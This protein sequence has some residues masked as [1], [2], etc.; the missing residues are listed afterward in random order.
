M[1]APTSEVSLLA[2]EMTSA[3]LAAKWVSGNRRIPLV[4]FKCCIV[5][6]PVM[7]TNDDTC[8]S[9]QHLCYKRCLILNGGFHLLHLVPYLYLC[10]FHIHPEQNLDLTESFSGF[11]QRRCQRTKREADGM[12]IPKRVLQCE[13]AIVQ[14]VLKLKY[15]AWFKK[16]DSISYVYI[17]WHVNDLHNIWK[18]RS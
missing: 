4:P 11:S 18:R 2:V 13:V 7:I 16:M 1:W 6:R 17:S 15:T 5:I 10:K 14:D 12:I 9:S 3:Y 8:R